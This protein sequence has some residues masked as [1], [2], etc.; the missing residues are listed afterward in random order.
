MGRMDATV[1]MDPTLKAALF[2]FAKDLESLAMQ[3][4]RPHLRDVEWRKHIADACDELGA[5]AQEARQALS[6]GYEAL[7]PALEETTRCLKAYSTELTAGAPVA[8]LRAKAQ[9]MSETYEDL[10]RRLK[11]V[12]G[13]TFI[14]APLLERMKPVNYRRN[15]FHV[16]TGLGGAAIYE[17]LLT[18]GQAVLIL[19]IL[20]SVAVTFEV[21]RRIWPAVNKFMI[22]YLFRDVVRPWEKRRPNSASWYTMALLIICALTPKLAAEIGVLVLAFGDPAASIVGRKWGELKLYRRK[23]VLGTLAFVVAATLV[24]VGLALAKSTTLS[25]L[26]LVGM[27]LTVAM[28]AAAAELFSDVVDDNATVPIT[29]ACVATLW[30]GA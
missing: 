15:V 27:A 13:P 30:L 4:H 11:G 20:L 14:R 2:Q 28:A 7:G 9:A 24:T 22:R 18:P 16:L 25:P 29:A 10:R 21:S 17:F 19:G 8:R 6:D 5:R 23:S 12:S 26:A 1:A 3:A